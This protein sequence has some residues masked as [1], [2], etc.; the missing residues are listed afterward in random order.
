MSYFKPLNSNENNLHIIRLAVLANVESPLLYPS[1]NQLPTN[2]TITN[3]GSNQIKINYSTIFSDIPSL[4]FGNSTLVSR[5]ISDNSF[6]IQVTNTSFQADI[7]IIGPKN[8]GPVFAVSNKGW[9]FSNDTSYNNLLYSDL[10]VGI[11]NDNPKFN[12]DIN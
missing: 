7:I 11:K 9:K 10:P 12:L 2:L 5:N 1:K 6:I 3:L 4:F 8:N